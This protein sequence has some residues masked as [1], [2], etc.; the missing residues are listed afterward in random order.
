MDSPPVEA[1][2]NHN[3]SKVPAVFSLLVLSATSE[4]KN[5]LVRHALG[6]KSILVWTHVD[7]GVNHAPVDDEYSGLAFSVPEIAPDKG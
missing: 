7:V 6:G 4:S 1:E 3:E 5:G 2:K